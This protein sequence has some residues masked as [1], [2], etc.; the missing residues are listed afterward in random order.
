MAMLDC[1][2]LPLTIVSKSIVEAWALSHGGS[3]VVA[4]CVEARAGGTVLG[5]YL[6]RQTSFQSP[7]RFCHW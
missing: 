5:S 7:A 3:L 1:W 6:D 2:L 4:G